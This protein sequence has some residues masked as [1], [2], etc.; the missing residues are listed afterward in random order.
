MNPWDNIAIRWEV[1]TNFHNEQSRHLASFTIE[2]YGQDT[3]KN[4]WKLYWNQSPRNIFEV[5]SQ[6]LSIRKI[7]GDFYEM[8]PS[9]GFKTT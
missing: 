2:N 9:S 3:L 4:D 8:E 7:N 5:L 6:D 1:K